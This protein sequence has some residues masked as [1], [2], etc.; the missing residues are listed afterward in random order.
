MEM[1][2]E[3][4]PVGRQPILEREPQHLIDRG[5]PEGVEEQYNTPA[6]EIDETLL[7]HIPYP[8]ARTQT[9]KQ[10]WAVG[11]FDRATRTASVR[12]VGPRWTR[13]IMGNDNEY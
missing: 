9:E 1:N 13:E 12:V 5:L 7:T 11:V 10:C 3:Q 6:V 4:E 8:G 2:W